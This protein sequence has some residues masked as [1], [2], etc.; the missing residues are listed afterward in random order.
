[1][2]LELRFFATFRTVVGEKTVARDYPDGSSV[3]DVLRALEAE[4]EAFEGALLDAEGDVKGQ[5]TVLRNGRDV[6]H[7]EG[8]ATPLSDGDALSL[9]PPVAGGDGATREEAYRGISLRLAR[10]YLEGLGAEER[11]AGDAETTVLVADDWRASLSA[12]R[13]SVSAG[14][15]MELTEVTVAFEADDEATLTDVVERFD[16]KA[17][18]A[19]G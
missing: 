9:F 13:V 14:S 19:G 12:E 8:T 2:E 11:E 3:G 5:V 17:M 1:M 6:V 7:L 4:H 18:R 15:A 10:H 16:R